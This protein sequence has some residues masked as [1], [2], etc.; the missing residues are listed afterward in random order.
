MPLVLP[1]WP[2]AGQKRGKAL[3]GWSA[4]A[5]SASSLRSWRVAQERLQPSA[6]MPLEAIWEPTDDGA[7]AAGA[8]RLRPTTADTGDAAAGG[9]DDA[10]ASS[11]QLEFPCVLRPAARPQGLD[12]QLQL[13]RLTVGEPCEAGPASGGAAQR[14]RARRQQPALLGVL[15]RAAALLAARLLFP[16]AVLP[17]M[18]FL[19]AAYGAS[20]AT[21]ATGLLLSPDARASA[22]SRLQRL[23]RRSPAAQTAVHGAR[24][25]GSL[26]Q[27]YG[28]PAA[29]LL[30]AAALWAYIH[31]SSAQIG[32]CIAALIPVLAGYNQTAKHCATLGL[33]G[34]AS[35]EL[36]RRQHKW[37]A[38]R[39]AH[40]LTDLPAAPPLAGA[41]SQWEDLNI[42]IAAVVD[43]MHFGS[44]SGGGGLQLWASMGVPG[45]ERRRRRRA[46]AA[47]LTVA[48][49]HLGAA[50]VEQLVGEVTTISASLSGSEEEMEGQLQ[51]LTP[52]EL[53]LQRA[54]Q[55]QQVQQLGAERW[56]DARQQWQGA[57]GVQAA[58]GAGAD[59]CTSRGAVLDSPSEMCCSPNGPARGGWRRPTQQQAQQGQAKPRAGGSSALQQQ[60]AAGASGTSSGSSQAEGGSRGPLDH[61]SETALR[62]AAAAAATGGNGGT[63]DFMH[64]SNW[65][66]ARQAAAAG[67]PTR[68][69]AVRSDSTGTN[70]ANSHSVHSY[71]LPGRG[72]TSSEGTSEAGAGGAGASRLLPPGIA[73]AAPAAAAARTGGAAPRQQ[74]MPV[75][76]TEGA[77][78]VVLPLYGQGDHEAEEARQLSTA[79]KLQ[80][81]L[82]ALQLLALFTPFLL[83]GTIMLL[84]ASRMDASA[85]RRAQ[86]QQRGQQQL[87]QQQLEGDGEVAVPATPAGIRLR[88]KAYQLLLGACRRSGAAFIKWGQWSSTREDIFPQ[89]FCTVLSELHDRAPV[90]SDAETR[91]VVEAAFGRTLEDLFVSF[92]ARPL[93]SGSIA[94]V[95]RARLLVDGETREVAVK[96]RHPG[97]ADRIW[98]DFQLLRPLAAMTT[99]VRTLKSLNLS[100][101]VAQFSHTMTAQ[102]DLRVEAEHLRRFYNNFKGVGSSV[103]VPEPIA[104]YCTEDV[105]VETFEPGKSVAHFVRTPHP[106]NTQIVA[107][108]VDTYLK[109]LLQDNFIHTDLHPGNIMVRPARANGGTT[110]GSGDDDGGLEAN[111]GLRDGGR[112]GQRRDP[113]E[114]VLLDF[115]LAQECSPRVRHHFISFLHMIARGDGRG[116]THHLLRWSEQQRCPD[117]AGLTV[118][119]EELFERRCNIHSEQGIDL[120]AVMKAVLHLARQF[121]VAIDSQYAELV[122]GVCVIVGF[123]TSLD[124]RVN[125]MDAA[126][127]CFLYYTLTGRVSGRLYM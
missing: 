77:V 26:A 87:E 81:A 2:W 56:Q 23:Q 121:E 85:A 107:L 63:Q 70:G 7:A 41:V 19:A 112:P 61:A 30:A 9:V 51:Q 89:E 80:L 59:A 67:G 45:R 46:E 8:P 11:L 118:A 102:T 76:V 28:E 103:R 20:A 106:Q 110:S 109:M 124:P 65:A 10:A 53:V 83:L 82:R 114:L 18:R 33:T 57:A 13:F 1:N 93:A 111:G 127:P 16:D 122:I 71:L 37:A 66:A 39:T 101:S 5:L 6:A 15:D 14:C 117:P 99:R 44:A 22:R 24:Q 32:E 54:Q 104:G 36:W 42:R 96:V 108:G 12:L 29:V 38:G 86:Q 94:Q 92:E 64:P 75:P 48:A 49:G 116:A 88:T 62:R 43:G 98:Q 73:L 47:A 84:L 120:D 126:T 115:G 58:M 97:V 35:E 90:H 79:V 95:H 125:L 17:A 25:L 52:H 4:P 119:M 100:D 21:Q 123:A 105:L 68:G 78:E 91:R 3:A 72:H 55:A 50:R 34:D 60:A 27:R 31:P 113:V 40:L 74:A 69:N